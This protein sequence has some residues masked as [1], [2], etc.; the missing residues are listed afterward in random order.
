[1]TK[2]GRNAACPCGSGKKYKKCCID[3][4]TNIPT[5]NKGV[6]AFHWSVDEIN[7][8]STDQIIQRL[9]G[10]GVPFTKELFLKDVHN[11][12]SACDLGEHWLDLYPI[13]ATGLDED[14]IWMAAIVL[15]ERLVPGV[16]NTEK[17]DDMMQDGYDLEEVE[18]SSLWLEVW[19][20]LKKRFTPDMK[21]IDDAEVVFSGMQ[22]LSNWVQDLEIELQNAA[23]VDQSFYKNRIEFCSEFC[24]LFPESDELIIYNMRSAAAESY[25]GLGRIEEGEKAFKL[26]IEDFPDSAWSYIDWGDMYCIIRLND[27]VPL[28]FEKAKQI[29]EMALS[30]DVEDKQE[31]EDRLRDLEEKYQKQI[32]E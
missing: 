19:E 17:L 4:Q 6:R 22:S 18:A 25:F 16:I 13:T 30:R 31:V 12:Y 27:A 1:M 9:Q 5:N 23:V 8:F 32:Q 7:A 2:I 21:S 15:W 28:D 10:F 29:Y 24:E 14:F 26:L 11:F 20:H 3:K